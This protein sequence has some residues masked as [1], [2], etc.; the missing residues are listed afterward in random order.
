AGGA[1]ARGP[2]GRGPA[3]RAVAIDESSV[4]G[5]P[6][7]GA[8]GGRSALGPSS[9]DGGCDGLFTELLLEHR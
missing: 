9:G 8:V 2:A 1:A 5:T 3:T 6:W 4:V 7:L